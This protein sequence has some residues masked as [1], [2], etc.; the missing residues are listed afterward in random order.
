MPCTRMAQHQEMFDDDDIPELVGSDDDEPEDEDIDSTLAKRLGNME[1][2]RKPALSEIMI[3]QRFRIVDPW[4]LEPVL[5]EMAGPI[6]LDNPKTIEE[7]PKHSYSETV[8]HIEWSTKAAEGTD[9]PDI[10]FGPGDRDGGMGYRCTSIYVRELVWDA[11]P[12]AIQDRWHRIAKVK[13][14]P[15]RLSTSIQGRSVLRISST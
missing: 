5:R 13:M 12:P 3:K 11:L 2:R 7:A 10:V 6:Q 8:K 1:L 14:V 9:D 4:K 15:S